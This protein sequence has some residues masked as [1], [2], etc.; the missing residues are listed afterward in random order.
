MLVPRRT[1]EKGKNEMSE[2]HTV[3]VEPN[4]TT[5]I[6]AVKFTCAGTRESDCHIY[7][8]AEEWHDDDGQERLAHDEC[9]LQGWFD[10]DCYA[11]YGEDSL[12][13]G[14]PDGVPNVA[15]AGAVEV[16]CEPGSHIT[17]W[18]KGAKR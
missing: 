11:Y 17:W 3:T 10:N 1:G 15:A 9:W 6:P 7:P 4:T 12:D 16:E 14:G 8:D 2:M 18:W 13:G 5:E